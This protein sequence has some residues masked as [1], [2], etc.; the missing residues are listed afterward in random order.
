MTKL[1]VV[2]GNVATERSKR[3]TARGFE[4]EERF[5]SARAD[6]FAGSERE[7]KGVGS[8]RSE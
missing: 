3:K 7:R 1:L 8:L 5:L 4:I 2:C 6:A